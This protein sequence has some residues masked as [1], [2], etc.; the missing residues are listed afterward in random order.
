M[1]RLAVLFLTSVWCFGCSQSNDPTAR[2]TDQPDL[3]GDAIRQQ[4]LQTLSKGGFHAA[5]WLPTAGH[6]ANV[7][8]KLRPI[9][10]VAQRLMAL[11]ALFTWASAPEDAVATDR[12]KAYVDRNDLRA[13]LTEEERA[14]LALSRESARAQHGAGIGWRLENMWALAWVLGF[15]SPPDPMLGQVP[16]DIS[17]AVVMEFLPGLDASVDDL[18]KKAK[19]RTQQEVIALEDIFYCSHNAVRSAQTGSKTS[20]PA[21][22]DPVSDGGA[23]HERRHALTW[24]ISPDTEWDETDLST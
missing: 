4:S 2:N 20:I 23:I 6:R 15:D 8:G 18:L 5:D 12:L 3:G 14:V 21:D 22:F 7:P 10:E 1:N 17:R 9:R 19:P 24:A 16:D 11:D 13:H